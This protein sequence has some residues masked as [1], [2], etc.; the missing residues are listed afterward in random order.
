MKHVLNIPTI[1]PAHQQNISKSSQTHPYNIP[2]YYYYYY[3]TPRR[4]GTTH[5]RNLFA[6]ASHAA[7]TLI[8][9]NKAIGS[10]PATSNATL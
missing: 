9:L 1:S 7:G 5:E 10:C 4:V 2:N 8:K 3:Q 6:A